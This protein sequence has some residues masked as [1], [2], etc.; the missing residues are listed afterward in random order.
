MSFRDLKQ[1]IFRIIFCYSLVC[2]LGCDFIYGILQKEGAEE[3]KILGEVIPFEYNPQV[4]ELQELLNIYG[5]SAG[6]PDGKFGAKTRKAIESF[7]RDQ[8]LK[9][10]RFV[11]KATWT[12]LSLLKTSG[13]IGEDGEIS[14]QALQTALH[15]AQLDPG[16]VDGRLGN[17]TLQALKDFQAVHGLKPDGVIGYRTISQLLKYLPAQ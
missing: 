8:G 9:V 7:Q 4:E 16:K 11:D 2:L 6:T 17:K 5:Y 12:K 3:K 14:V 15:N 1:T 13:L 10:S